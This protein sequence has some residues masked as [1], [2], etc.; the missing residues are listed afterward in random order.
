MNKARLLKRLKA[1]QENVTKTIVSAT[2]VT[3]GNIIHLGRVRVMRTAD[4]ALDLGGRAGM[5]RR[6]V[7][8][9]NKVKL[10]RSIRQ[11]CA[12]LSMLQKRRRSRRVDTDMLAGIAFDSNIQQATAQSGAWS[13]NRRSVRDA[14]KIVA[15]SV[16]RL[17]ANLLDVV[18]RALRNDP[19]DWV[20]VDKMWDETG[21][22]VK[23]P[24]LAKVSDAWHVMVTK[25][26]VAWGWFDTECTG[27]FECVIPPVPVAST[28]A[29]AMFAAWHC[30]PAVADFFSFRRDILSLA[31]VLNIDLSVAD[32]AASNGRL[33][34]HE[35]NIMAGVLH[36]NVTCRNHANHLIQGMLIG[37]VFGVKF[38]NDHFASALLLR[39]ESHFIRLCATV[40][41]FVQR[42][43]KPPLPGP[44]LDQDK[45]FAAE[46]IDFLLRAKGHHEEESGAKHARPRARPSSIG[47]ASK[48]YERSLRTVF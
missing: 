37:G 27:G 4:E 45:Q 36:E 21:Q 48:D 40:G 13:Y 46:M 47:V 34:A 8:G 35:L 5:R 18:R 33:F 10:P 6:H 38:M 42:S 39:M 43:S 3:L 17:Q 24:M 32:N 7:R 14:H 29:D 41:R 16:C 1:H 2:N 30:H 31:K 9:M 23:I 28:S 44:P 26:N 19:P 22:K 20:V 15:H 25:L 12:C 11:A